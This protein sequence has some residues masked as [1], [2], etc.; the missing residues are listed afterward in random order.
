MSA[1]GN[2]DRLL[3]R[4]EVQLRTGLSRS[5]IYRHMRCGKFPAPLKVGASAVRWPA[6]E[7]EAW[8][9]SLPRSHGDGIRRTGGGSADQ[10]AA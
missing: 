6:S 10:S 9:A 4:S 2:E 8:I 5:S 1:A 7:V 3:T